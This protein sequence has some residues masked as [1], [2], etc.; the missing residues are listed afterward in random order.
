[1]PILIWRKDCTG[2]VN[3]AVAFDVVAIRCYSIHWSLYFHHDDVSV[4]VVL[5]HLKSLSKIPLS[6]GREIP[7]DFAIHGVMD[8][9]DINEHEA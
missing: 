7:Q 9:I 8:H 4:V 2:K 5:Q 6:T 1:M 3:V